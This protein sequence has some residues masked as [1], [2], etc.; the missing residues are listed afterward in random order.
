MIANLFQSIFNDDVTSTVSN[1]EI[2]DFLL[3]IIVAL[4][5][6]LFLAF[7]HTYK[8]HYTISFFVTVTLIPAIVCVIILM[9]NGSIGAGIAVAG[10]FSLVRFRSAP[11]T[12][13]EISAIF[14]AM[15]SGLIVGMGFL[16]F[17]V[18][19]AVVLG[20]ATVLLETVTKRGQE[21]DKSQKTLNITIPED[22]NYGDVFEDIFTE[23]T[24]K[25]DVVSVKTSNM[26]SMFRL[27]YD[28]VL[29][30]AAREKEFIDALRCRNGNL[31]IS[32]T[33]QEVAAQYEL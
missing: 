1:I 19:F 31:E 14:L 20:A 10:A 13:K 6:G 23:Y 9:V 8:T 2:G 30:D 17:A 3:C 5:I 25:C 24:D 18:V 16:G 4:V 32:I 21:P 11:G 22:L 28:L 15:A 26:G 12:A 27:K 33:R 7:V 29:K